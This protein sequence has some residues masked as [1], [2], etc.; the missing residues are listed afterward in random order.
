MS[1]HEKRSQQ[2]IDEL[3]AAYADKIQSS[4]DPTAIPQSGDEEI[5]ALQETI[6]LL[7][8]DVPEAPSTASAESIK[9]NVFKAWEKQYQPK[10]TLGEKLNQMLPKPVKPA[11]QS[12]TRRRQ[13]AALRFTAAAALVIIAAFIVLPAVGISDGSTSGTAFGEV[14]PWGLLG[15]L[16][17]LGGFGIWWWLTTRRK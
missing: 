7:N 1:D 15:G 13:I 14:G 10:A 12:R 11:Y 8:Q 9:A 3:L 6:M 16:L 5:K 17:L 2:S 4:P